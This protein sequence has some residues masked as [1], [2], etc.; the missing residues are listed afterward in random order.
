MRKLIFSILLGGLCQFSF[1]QSD[2]DALRY[3]SSDIGSTA[4]S[5]GAGGAFGALGADL[6]SMQINPAGLALFRTNSF[7]ISGQMA[8]AKSKTEYQGN[9][10]RD[11]DFGLNVPSVGLVFHNGKYE[12]RRPAKK[13]WLNT[14]F[15]MAINQTNNFNGIVNYNGSN[16][17]NSMLN[18]FAERAN[19][20][21][22]NELSASSEEL[23]Y[24]Y[25]DLET[26]AWEAYLID[27]VGLRT[28]HPA[29]DDLDRALSQKNVISTSGST[30]DISLSLSS[31]YENKFYL[32]GGI[33]LTTVRYKEENRFT[34][35]DESTNLDNWAAWTLE[36]NLLTKGIGVSGNLGIIVR[37]NEKLRVGAAIKTPTIYSLKDEYYDELNV[38]FDDGTFGNYQSSEGFYEYKVL[39]P[40]RTTL[41]GA[42]IFGK[43]GFIS[44][45]V[46]I[47]DYSMMRLRPAISAFEIANDR[48]G[49]KY[50]RA[51]NLRIGGEYVLNVVRLRAGFARYSSPL[52]NARDNN[53]TRTFLT[54][55]IGIQD[56]RWALDMAVVQRMGKEQIQP[57]TLDSG[58][59][60]VATN[61]ATRNSLVL[62]LTTKF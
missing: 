7:T 50:G 30:N 10:K 59:V 14:N 34:E 36:Q 35:V 5:M 4:R 62:T 52:T 12:N 61:T 22:I 33:S 3:S 37:P 45:D 43:S 56:K 1:G 16:D 27:S 44:T 29:I 48:I 23:S 41:S 55:G 58:T 9:T 26:M 40:M 19:G 31:N 15:A 20:L 18:Y 8:N 25:N 60:P 42:Y 53:L 46:E 38:D 57:Y 6:S 13:G 54:T 49:E 17:Q 39:S 21:S 32:G 28:Y 24:G 11:Y 2:L 51:V 47:M